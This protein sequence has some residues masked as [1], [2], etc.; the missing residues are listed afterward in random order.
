MLPRHPFEHPVG[1][2]PV[3]R[4]SESIPRA[5][6]TTGADARGAIGPR[7]EVEAFLDHRLRDEL[8]AGE[9]HLIMGGHRIP[10]PQDSG[11]LTDGVPAG[12]ARI[13]IAG[14]GALGV[15]R[16]CGHRGHLLRR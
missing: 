8:H 7:A 15:D 4:Q 16:G 11:L 1:E 14:V 3:R 9:H 6:R 2:R 10:Q 12:T 13:G 5:T